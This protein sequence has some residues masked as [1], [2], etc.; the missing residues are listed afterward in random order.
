LQARSFE[1]LQLVVWRVET[2]SSI[3]LP[4]L[5]VRLPAETNSVKRAQRTNHVQK[6][7]FKLN[8]KGKFLRIS[9]L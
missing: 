6:R 5:Q 7:A 3:G 8:L 9:N 1:N 4:L 2:E